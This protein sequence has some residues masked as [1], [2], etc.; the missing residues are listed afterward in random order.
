MSLCIHMNTIGKDFWPLIELFF[1]GLE[2][3]RKICLDLLRINEWQ[4]N[5]DQKKH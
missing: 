4:L 2:R 5:A 3:F 1:C